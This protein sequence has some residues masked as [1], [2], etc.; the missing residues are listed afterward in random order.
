MV[1]RALTIAGSDSGGGAGIQADLKTF[2]A[3]SV[4]GMSA[5]TAVT[6]QDTMGVYRIVAIDPDVVAQQIDVV[7]RD[8]G[9]DAIKI[10][11][12]FSADIIDAVVDR[13]RHYPDIPVVLDPVMR[14]KGGTSLLSP[15]AENQM[16]EQLLPLATV[17]TPNLPE[18]EAL[19]G[20][21]IRSPEDMRSAG[22]ALLQYGVPYVLVK[23]G[24]LD[25]Y[26]ANDL[27]VSQHEEL[28]LEAPRLNT[29][30]THGTGC[31][32]SSAIAAGLSQGHDVPQ[33]VIQA[34]NYVTQAILEA[35]SL[36][37][38]HG[39]LWHFPENRL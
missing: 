38:G 28:W 37:H 11:M 10:G 21:I 29:V 33:S 30:N 19:T 27:L 18:A 36:G 6:V 32:L 22:T 20:R 7:I 39:P 17:I 31:T 25:G 2:S 1:A 3:F 23:G 12:L 26:P 9:V 4:Y 34:K 8:L 24:H 13:L 14:A 15:G 16:R 35:P 5:I